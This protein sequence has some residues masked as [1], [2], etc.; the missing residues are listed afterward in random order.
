MVEGG[1]HL[2]GRI[3][4]HLVQGHLTAV[5]YKYEIMQDDNT[6]AHCAYVV[7]DFLQQQQIDRMDWPVQ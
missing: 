5:R 1:I 2:R 4:L 3:R 7:R 6:T